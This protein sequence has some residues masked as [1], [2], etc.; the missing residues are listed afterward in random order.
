[1]SLDTKISIVVFGL[2]FIAFLILQAYVAN[3][4]PKSNKLDSKEEKK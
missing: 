2:I 3:R 1:M 4:Q